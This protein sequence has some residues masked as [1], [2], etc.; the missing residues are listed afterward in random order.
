[1]RTD[2]LDW[3]QRRTFAACAWTANGLAR[4]KWRAPQPSR[5]SVVLPALNEEATVGAIVAAIRTELMEE[6]PLVDEIVV[7]DSGSVDQTAAVA[8]AA[9]ATVVAAAEILPEMGNVPGKGEA[10]WKSLYATTGDIVVFVDSDLHD[11][12]TAFVVGLVGPL[13]T[14]PD[15]HYV[16]G[17]YDRPLRT[18][19]LSVPAG[20]GR[21]TELLARP[22]LNLYWPLLAGFVQPLAGEYA[23]RRSVLEQV[24][25]VSGYGVELGLLV[26]LLGLV[27]LDG[28]AQCDLGE[29]SHGH[30]HIRALGLMSS[31]I[32]QTAITRLT[33]SGRL[34]LA[35]P[36]ETSVTQFVREGS[37][38]RSR[39]SEVVVS[40]RPPMATVDAYLCRQEELAASAL[41]GA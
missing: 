19:E 6:V 28:L 40:E 9:G 32:M 18:G 27:G 20:G 8:A 41:P 38:Y 29:R 36:V 1:L 37:G 24:P 39:R 5:I 13:L 17:V 35:E 22:L 2:V 10:L 21:V 4:R 23:G 25:F 11:F 3:Y 12:S 15:I 33:R 7:V 26:D 14:Q 34:S 31:A 30:Q 16:K